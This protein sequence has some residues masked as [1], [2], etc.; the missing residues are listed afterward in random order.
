MF[1]DMFSSGAMTGLFHLAQFPPDSSML[2]QM[3]DVL[4]F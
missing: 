2:S 1:A 3:A 4:P